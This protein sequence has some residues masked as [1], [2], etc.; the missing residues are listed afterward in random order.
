MTKLFK[1]Q[2]EAATTH[3]HHH[4][5]VLAAVIERSPTCDLQP[6][7]DYFRALCQSIIGQQLSVKAA[8][9]IRD[10][11]AALGGDDYPTPA[12]VVSLPADELRT[13]G[14][15]R[16]KVIYLK[17][18]AQH[19]TDERL[20]VARL[21]ELPNEAIMV[22]LTDVKGIGEWTAHMF[23]I[24]CLGRLDILP[25]GDLGVRKGME[26]LYELPELPTPL[27]MQRIAER[28]Q[29]TGYESVAAWYVW[30]SIDMAVAI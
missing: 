20:E 17:D 11:F 8:R 3:L 16:A 24:F 27:E 7:G 6:H 28:N 2:L 15:S 22:E 1:K 10:R 30:R 13:V 29:W 26:G 21:P 9:T 18:L 14:L 19:V 23:L 5:P 12:Q 4:D 25:T